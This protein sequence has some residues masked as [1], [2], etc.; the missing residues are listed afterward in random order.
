MA[1]RDERRAAER[2]DRLAGGVLAGRHLKATPSDAADRQAIPAASRL[3]RI[4]D[5]YPPI[6]AAL[7]P[8]PGR[9]L[10]TPG[11]SGGFSVRRQDQVGGMWSVCPPLPCE[12]VRQADKRLLTC[13]CHG[14]G[15]DTEGQSMREGYPLPALPFV[16]VRVRGDGLVEV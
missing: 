8:A 5:R 1:D 10:G 3:A 7:P 9:P 13:P 11:A 12:L 4:P 2:L 6:S 16:R 14:L 15:F